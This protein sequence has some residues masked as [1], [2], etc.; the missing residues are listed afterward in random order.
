MGLSLSGDLS[1]VKNI[2]TAPVVVSFAVTGDLVK[3]QIVLI[4]SSTLVKQF[5]LT[6]MLQTRFNF[7]Y[8]EITQ[9]IEMT[10]LLTRVMYLDGKSDKGID[11]TGVLRKTVYLPS[12]ASLKTLDL[13]SLNLRSKV[14]LSGLITKQISIS[15]DLAVG[16][17]V[18]LS[19]V[20]AQIGFEVLGELRGSFKMQ[21]TVDISLETA[22]SLSLIK[23]LIGAVSKN[24]A[25][26]GYLSNNAFG[27][28]IGSSTMVRRKTNREMIR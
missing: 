3:T 1:T 18:P 8:S 15:G 24:T 7:S 5:D 12:A 4:P 6:G 14:A 11:I 27:V 10:G 22:G 13:V 9:G 28:D 16:K 20:E 21:G 25:L 19:N 2:G 17:R 26:D 23:Q